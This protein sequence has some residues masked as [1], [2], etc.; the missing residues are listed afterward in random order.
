MAMLLISIRFS[1]RR[2]VRPHRPTRLPANRVLAGHN[3]IGEEAYPGFLFHLPRPT[4]TPSG[5]SSNQGFDFCY[6]KR[7]YDRLAHEGAESVRLHLGADPAYQDRLLRF[8]ENHDE[9]RAAAT[10]PPGKERAAAIVAATLPGARLIYEGQL[11]GRRVRPPVFLRRRPVETADPALSA[12]YGR[13]LRVINTPLFREGKW[14]L[15]NCTGWPDNSSYRNLLAWTWVRSS[16]RYLVA[17]NLSD[18]RSQARIQIGWEGPQWE[19]WHLS[20]VLSG[21]TFDRSG[22]EIRDA[23]LYVE[24]EP[25]GSHFFRCSD[26]RD[27]TAAHAG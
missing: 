19:S 27:G 15:C 9:P 4:G 11:E 7:L 24:L 10:F 21:V 6:D 22:P 2:R 5:H 1:N 26:N 16:E 13:L 14:S 12:F 3:L 25:W 8:I 23:G 17:V 20:D 18:S